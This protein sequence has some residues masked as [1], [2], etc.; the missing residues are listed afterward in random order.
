M[1][2][3]GVDGQWVMYYSRD[4][5]PMTLEEWSATYP[6]TQ[7][8]FEATKRV[9]KTTVGD[10]EVST[11][12]LGLDHSFMEG[13]PLIFETMIFGGEYDSECWRYSTEA[14][15]LEGHEAAV[16]LLQIDLAAQEVQ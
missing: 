7:E 13:P 8:E 10:W 4:G 14:Q 11:V 12:W 15:A 5:E 1:M 9:A 2:H 3:R 6:E 16:K